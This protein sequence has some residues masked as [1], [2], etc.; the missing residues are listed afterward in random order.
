[1]LEI[2]ILAQA[3][4][5]LFFGA[6]RLERERLAR[7][8]VAREQLLRGGLV[9]AQVG[10]L[11]LEPGPSSGARVV[12]DNQAAAQLLAWPELDGAEDLREGDRLVDLSRPDPVL[13][14]LARYLAADGVSQ[15]G[16]TTT[17]AGRHVQY[18]FSTPDT[19]SDRGIITAQFVD[20][21]ERHAIEVANEKALL[22]EQELV[23][24]LRDLN[25]Q[26][27]DF[28]SS[29]SH[30]LRTPITS[31]LGFAEELEDAITDPVHRDYV[32]VI[33]RNARR[34]ADL[35]EDLLELGS[36]STNTPSRESA[37]VDVNAVIE[38]CVFEQSHGTGTSPC[39]LR[40]LR[41]PPGCNPH[42]TISHGS[43]RTF[44]PTPSSS[45]SRAEL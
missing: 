22:H 44:S 6:G 7:Q 18:F 16:V 37:P 19:D 5:V 23:D 20:I 42:P 40:L 17:L 33:M 13:E 2:F 9:G 25:R 14:I 29:V 15:A 39:R 12:L 34:L 4:S 38:D 11:I 26:K 28:V 36:I 3:G 1:M 41:T 24:Q 45:R 21:T 27:D 8:V 32:Q 35:V 30:E 43:F 10:M 31:V